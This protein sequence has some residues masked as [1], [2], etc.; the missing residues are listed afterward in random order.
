MTMKPLKECDVIDLT[1]D[2][3]PDDSLTMLVAENQSVSPATTS[4]TA[5]TRRRVIVIDDD[6]DDDD[7]DGDNTTAVMFKPETS[8]SDKKRASASLENIKSND[9]SPSSTGARGKCK[10]NGNKVKASP[11]KRL[12]RFRPNATMSIIQRIERALSQRLYLINASPIT[13][14]RENGGPSITFHILGSTGNVYLVTIGKVPSC[15]CP[16]HEKGNLC[17]HILFIMLKVMG[18]PSN[19]NL[20]YQAAYLTQELEEI[21]E[22]YQQRKSSMSAVLANE[23]VRT[24][25]AKIQSGDDDKKISSSVE[26]K[27]VEGEDCPI[28][29]DSLGNSLSL[30]TFCQNSCGTNF[31]VEC[32][33]MWI[34]QCHGCPTCPACREEWHEGH[35]KK[36][37]KKRGHNDD[38]DGGFTN[39]GR[40]QG[41]SRV[42]DTSTFHRFRW[43]DD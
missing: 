3:E 27:K 24:E 7:D 43:D 9:N 8:K 4:S 25:Y 15:S 41:Q 11:E 13:T 18:L 31:H 16:D 36:K 35:T 6:D 14:C 12:R 17:K 10:K 29:F 1:R 33:K 38:Q 42:R 34:S 32:M 22:L 39:L 26:R 30:L 21:F 20:V 28:C 40:L 2:F 23:A 5:S 19:S 37:G